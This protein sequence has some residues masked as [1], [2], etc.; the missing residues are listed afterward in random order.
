MEVAKQSNQSDNVKY[1]TIW[2]TTISGGGVL[3]PSLYIDHY[4][5]ATN[6]QV[7]YY[8]KSMGSRY[9]EINRFCKDYS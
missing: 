3:S 4:R 8:N 2:S 9:W 1:A 6:P 7:L 5:A